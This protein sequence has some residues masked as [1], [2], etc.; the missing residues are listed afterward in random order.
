MIILSSH[1]S[2]KPPSTFIITIYFFVLLPG[3]HALKKF[4]GEIM[5]M[6]ILMGLK[7]M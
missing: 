7:I 4:G 5:S 1:N 6:V 3:V 2:N